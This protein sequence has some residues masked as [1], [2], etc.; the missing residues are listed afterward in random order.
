MPRC[1]FKN[2]FHQNLGMKNEM[3]RQLKRDCKCI[4]LTG[5]SESHLGMLPNPLAGLCYILWSAQW[6]DDCRIAAACCWLDQ[7]EG[8]AARVAAVQ[9]QACLTSGFTRMGM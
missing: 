2:N 3:Y 8:V 9:A 6:E 7:V 5:V 1:F 4:F